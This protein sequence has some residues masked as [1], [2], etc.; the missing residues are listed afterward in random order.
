MPSRPKNAESGAAGFTLVEALVSLLIVAIS[1]G[2]IGALAA[3]SLRS[4][5]YVER[6]LSDVNASRMIFT[7][8]PKR[9]AV[10][11]GS[12]TGD[13]ADHQ[14]RIDAGPFLAD[15]VDPKSTS[16]W[17]PQQVAL[18]VQ[19]PGGAILRFDTIRLRKKGSP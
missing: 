5:L 13:L 2:A 18:R 16:P 10:P 4:G 6:H 11:N 1:L 15:F 19:G 3:S 7:G 14:W 8:L 9:E 17:E 12:L